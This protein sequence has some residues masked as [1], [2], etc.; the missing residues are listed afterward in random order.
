MFYDTELDFVKSYLKHCHVQ[1]LMITRN[2]EHPE[3]LDFG[4]RQLLGIK[5]EY[6]KL[7]RFIAGQMQNN[8]IYRIT[9]S[10]FCNYYMMPLPNCD[11]PSALLIGPFLMRNPEKTTL[12]EL[13]EKYA[14][15][16]QVLPV[17]EHFYSNL[18]M[19]ADDAPLVTLVHTFAEKIWD[20]ANNF[21]METFESGISEHYAPAT[22]T[23]PSL[24]DLD[25]TAFSMQTL[26]ARYAVE[27]ELLLAVSQ[28]K[29]H[30]AEVIISNMSTGTMEERT[31][32]SLRN[33]KNYTIIMN[34]LL[35][36]AAEQGSVH[37]YHIDKLSSEFARKVELAATV[38][39]CGKL[40]REMI[41]KYC[42]LVKNHSMKGY[43]LLVQKVIT[44]IDSD[45]TA[46]LSLNAMATSL[47]VNASY[48]STQFKKETGSTLT[49]YVN[50]KRVE[51]AIL[52]L[53][54][55][56]LQIQTIALHCGIPDVNYFTKIFKKYI[57]K[58]PKEY[59]DGIVS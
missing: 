58:T 40:Q 30:Q 38:E 1:C 2:Y 51:H 54:S 26:E 10:F 15:P 41:R 5:E 57:R 34:T 27:N 53:N 46:D 39:A 12:L 52:L 55:T 17:L 28:G 56:P 25:T 19:F 45:L 14:V 21:T 59:R 11:E 47:N 18:P 35:R 33:L 32:D 13:S 31:S 22:L 24:A 4:L 8:R 16:P 20:G 9:D 23:P 43:S 7:I 37:P 3:K 50:K 49:N 6:E 44:K 48:L 29:S 36:K 42:L